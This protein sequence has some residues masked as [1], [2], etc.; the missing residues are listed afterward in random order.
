MAPVPLS[1][2]AGAAE[3]LEPAAAATDGERD[4]DWGE[5]WW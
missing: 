2:P 3:Q 4:R 1:S 5:A